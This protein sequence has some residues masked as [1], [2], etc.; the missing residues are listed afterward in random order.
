[1]KF[2]IQDL[3]PRL[4]SGDRKHGLGGAMKKVIRI[5]LTP[6]RSPRR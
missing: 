5:G 6:R 3:T 4:V 2:K 1:M